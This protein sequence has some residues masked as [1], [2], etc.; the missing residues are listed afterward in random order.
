MAEPKNTAQLRM[1]EWPMFRARAGKSK[2]T[3]S[4]RE[5]QPF[6]RTAYATGEGV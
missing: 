1:R 5:G 2:R 6:P 3:S 4:R